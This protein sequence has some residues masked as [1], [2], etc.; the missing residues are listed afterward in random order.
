MW[1]VSVR[2]LDAAAALAFGHARDGMRPV[3]PVELIA[4]WNALIE[5]AVANHV[6]R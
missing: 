3:A 5:K 2:D 1:T 6:A 4:R